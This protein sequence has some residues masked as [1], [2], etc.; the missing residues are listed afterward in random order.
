MHASVQ[1]PGA[2]RLRPA[3]CLTVFWLSFWTSGL[4]AAPVDF[5]T[6]IA[7]IL[8]Q[9]CVHCHNETRKSGELSLSFGKDLLSLEFVVPGEPQNSHL[10]DTVTADVGERPSM[11][12]EGSP[13]SEEQVATIRQWIAEG[14]KW[15]EGFEVQPKPKADAS[16]WSLQQVA[17]VPLPDVLPGGSTHPIDRFIQQRLKQEQLSPSPLADRRTLIR[18][19]YYDLIGLPPTPEAVAAFVAD[20]D[21]KVYEK[22]VDQLLESDHFGE[23]WARHWLDIAHYAD[24]HGFERDKLRDNAW[25]YRDYVI[26]AFN[27]DKPYDRFLREQIA[28][29]LIAPDDPDSVIATGFLAAGPWDYVGQ[30]E[31]KSPILRRAARAL[32]LDDMV[33]QVMTSTMAMTVNCAR[34]HDHKLDPITQREYYQLTAVFAGLSRKDR[35][36]SHAAQSDYE[37]NKARLEKSIADLQSENA[38]LQGQGVDLADIVGGGNGYGSGKKGRGIDPRTGLVQESSVSSL[39]DVRSGHFSASDTPFVDGVFI[40]ASSK[41]QISSTGVFVSELPNNSGNAW[42]AIRNG[43]VTSQFS[44]KLG[45]TDYNADGHSMIGLHANAGI[46]FDLDAMRDAL[47]AG[48]PDVSKTDAFEFSTTVGYGG[49]TV[50]PSAEFHILFD[51]E[52]I[53]RKRIGRNDVVHVSRAI[54][55]K[56][57]FLTLISTDGGNGYGHDQVSF[58]DPRIRSV[59]TTEIAD[60]KR[61]QIEKLRSQVGDLESELKSLVAPPVFFGVASQN[62]PAVHV[63]SRG[64]P[65]APGEAVSPGGLS[66]SKEPL[67]FGDAATSDK[68]RRLA[69]ADWIV[70]PQNP[71]TARVIVNRLWHWHFGSGI[72]DTPSDFGFGGSLPTHPELLDWLATELVRQKWSLKAIHRLIVTSQTYQQVSHRRDGVIPSGEKDPTVIDVDNK[73]LWRMNGRRLEAEAVRDSVLAISGKLNAEMYG[74]G[75]RDF[76]YQ[77]AYAP[78]YTYKTADSPELWR[79]SV[80]RFTVRTTPSSFMT[81]L[82]CPDPANFTPKRNVTTTALQSLAMFNNDFMLRQSRYLADRIAAESDQVDNQIELAFQLVLV[83]SPSMKELQGARELVQQFGLLH[84]CRA[85]LNANEFVNLD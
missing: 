22:L 14:A 58:G 64:D 60:Q 79:R 75:F 72:V 38:Q 33:T 67:E 51:G 10:I 1:L 59:A 62:P 25:R 23:R 61:Q 56:T 32:D 40:P 34:C 39:S 27:D 31:A 53:L 47:A 28:G 66:W 21:P 26:R 42:D 4:V 46:T 78:I 30:V 43:P 3:F 17:D 85:L 16:W 70:D 54:P 73:L 80:Y 7:P 55:A 49:R 52:L 83:R 76:D 82:D 15:P 9:H 81:A 65:E 69:I 63:L 2:A 8:Q 20:P 44:S 68:E 77:E 48:N 5:V 84:L 50:E 36:V 11:P 37:S 74:P 6:Q 45:S 12:E 41:T 71:L 29:D 19:L 13:L 35:V 24:T 57:R 18:R